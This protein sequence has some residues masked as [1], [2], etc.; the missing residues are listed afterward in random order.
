MKRSNWIVFLNGICVGMFCV[1]IVVIVGYW[2]LAGW[3]LI[4]WVVFGTLGW[5]LVLGMFIARG[6]RFLRENR[7]WL[8]AVE[9]NFRSH[10]QMFMTWLKQLS[11][12]DEIPTDDQKQQIE[13]LRQEIAAVRTYQ[14]QLKKDTPQ[15]AE[16]SS[17]K[18]VSTT[19]DMLEKLLGSKMLRPEAIPALLL[20]VQ[21]QWQKLDTM[22]TYCWRYPIPNTL[23]Q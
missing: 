4:G 22:L 15:M 18:E 2:F 12:I 14:E 7:S 1:E 13:E 5:L 11:E 10:M 21:A 8:S 3:S 20:V 6:L 17:Y 23:L 9:A 19:L 16:H